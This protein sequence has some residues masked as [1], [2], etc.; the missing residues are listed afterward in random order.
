MLPA[1]SRAGRRLRLGVGIVGL[2]VLV[3]APVRGQELTPATPNDAHPPEPPAAHAP[4][5]PDPTF[6]S[7]LLSRVVDGETILPARWQNR[8]EVLAYEDLVLHARR[9][10]TD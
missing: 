5:S 3:A 8:E 10:P 7:D 6:K 4:G 9:T 2:A 1:L